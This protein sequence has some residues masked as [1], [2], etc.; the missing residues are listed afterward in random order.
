VLLE[1]R[2]RYCRYNQLFLTLHVT[3]FT[4]GLYGPSPLCGLLTKM[5]Q[6]TL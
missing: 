6:T 1:R 5:Q 3:E 4:Y 2:D